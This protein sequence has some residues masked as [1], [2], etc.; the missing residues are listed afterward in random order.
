M[1]DLPFAATWTVKLLASRP[2]NIHGDQYQ[3]L[4]V[5]ILTPPPVRQMLLK[6]PAHA[7]TGPL[8]PGE[9]REVTLLLGQVTAVR[10]TP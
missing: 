4:A 1:S 10:P 9:T 7:I 5:E 2:Y 8:T 6:V 3:E